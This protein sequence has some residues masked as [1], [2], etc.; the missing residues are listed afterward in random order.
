MKKL[1]LCILLIAMSISY[2]FNSIVYADTTYARALEGI[3]L[4]KLTTNSYELED[5]IC[6][7]EKSYFVEIIS[8]NGDSYKVNY[9]GIQGYVK[10]NDV[11]P[12][13]T[14]PNTPFPYNIKLTLESDCNLRSSPT[15]KSL[16]NNVI[17]TLYAGENDFTFIGRIFS[18]EAIDFGGTTWYYVNYQGNYGYIYN[19]YIKSI[20]PIYENTE[21]ISYKSKE[22]TKTLN[23]ISHTPSLIIIIILL[24]PCLLLLLI[25]YLPRKTRR[26][27]KLIKESN[28]I[29]KY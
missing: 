26:K 10:K 11:K 17:T 7:V 18:D 1:I 23:P 20:S 5:I 13:L 21:N 4:Y 19:K 8:D 2:N 15:T 6:L 9:N 14:K 29:D 16:T 12:T 28:I 27:T 3:N 24:L 25:L 22:I